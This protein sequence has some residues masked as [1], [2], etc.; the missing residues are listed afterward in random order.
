MNFSL[1]EITK[2][3]LPAFTPYL[4]PQAAEPVNEGSKDIIAIGAVT[5]NKTCGAAA[6]EISGDGLHIVSL[7][8]DTQARGFGIG[9]A[10]LRELESMAG[11]GKVF[12]SW[13]LPENDFLLTS[14][15]FQGKGF[16][17]ISYG[18]EIFRLS[19][20]DLQKAPSLRAAFLP[21]YR[22]D[23]NIV[24]VSGFSKSELEELLAD[25]SI[26]PFL[27]LI[28][29]TKSELSQPTCLG[30]RYQG[31]IMAYLI[32]TH[33]DKNSFA[34]RAAF[35]RD[36]SPPAVFHL[37]MAAAIKKA[38]EKLGKDFYVF[39]SPVSAPAR[40]LAMQ[41]SGGNYEVWREG[42]CEKLPPHRI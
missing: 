10:L 7:F 35:S 38:C 42:F 27:R 26:P 30:Y 40:H 37:L 34:L 12:A 6:G 22:P 28:N 23:G 41:L 31:R 20:K 16:S 15:F 5:G 17:E 33:S 39:L 18:E 13:I 25:N 3:L 21:N 32:S 36:G 2:E 8:V 1:R 4:L 24:P 14:A 9:T 11:R 29:F 19:S